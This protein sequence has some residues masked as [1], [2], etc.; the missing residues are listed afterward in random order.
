MGETDKS[1]KGIIQMADDHHD[2]TRY[3]RYGFERDWYANLLYRQ[4]HQWIVW[5]GIA[6]RFRQKQLKSWVPT[7]VTNKF[8]SS[9][10]A[11]VSLVLR[12][13][14]EMMWKPTDPND[15]EQ[16]S[17]AETYTKATELAK[18]RTLFRFWRHEA[19]QWMVYT[20]NA[21]PVTFYDP[22]GGSDMSVP[23]LKC[24]VC[25]YEEMPTAFEQ[26]CPQCEGTNTSYVLENGIPKEEK[27]KGGELITEVGTPFEMFFDFTVTRWQFLQEIQRIKH[28]PVDYFKR[29][30]P[31]GKK[32]QA[33]SPS[34]ISEFYAGTLAYL[35][36]S[37]GI[38]SGAASAGKNPTAPEHLYLR[39]PD[40]DFPNGLYLIYSGDTI[41]EKSDLPCKDVYGNYILPVNHLCFDPIPGCALGKTVGNDLRPKQKQRNELESLIQLI[42]MRCANPVW[43]VP[44]GTDVEGFSGEPG[45]VL[46]SIQITPNASGEP[47][48]LAGENIPSSL[49]EW[50]KNIDAD[51]EEITSIYDV[52]KGQTPPGVT[53]GYAIQLLTERGQSRWGPLFQRWEN[54]HTDWGMVVTSYIKNYMP[55]EQLRLMLGEHGEWDLEKFKSDDPIRMTLTVE[56]GST[57]PQSALAEQALID[58]A[59]EKGLIDPTDPANKSQLLRSMGLSR[60]DNQSDWDMKDAAREEEAFLQIAAQV[61]LSAVY[62]KMAFAEESGDI[63]GIQT[64]I[65]EVK[66]TEEVAIR[67]RPQ[68][69]NNLIHLW[70]HKRFAKTDKFLQMP[71]EWQAVWMQHVEATAQRIMQE[72]MMA[73]GMGQ[74]PGQPEPAGPPKQNAGPPKPAQPGQ[75]SN[76]AASPQ[77][78]HAPSPLAMQPA[79]P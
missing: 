6:R 50:M 37:P 73:A 57:K 42:T 34:T 7:P 2:R 45:A 46:K 56:A 48:R 76:V 8:A 53:A 64:L 17:L 13:Q 43:I 72:S 4:G 32:V 12:V 47:R 22:K 9:L 69:D 68:I 25:N 1:D 18:E 63:E 15:E 60:F 40:D 38:V 35:S 58:S 31:R 30:G 10:D 21:F 66:K 20:G 79:I 65:A 75:P 78:G 23:Y 74:E 29:Y 14:P 62:Q 70:S 24:D 77:G 67:F 11:L 44:Y 28:R 27:F 3:M 49:I 71:A 36:G 59:I 33:G 39:K 52:L 16:K 41:L 55:A 5:D 26:G 61:D 54:G 19:A 51:F